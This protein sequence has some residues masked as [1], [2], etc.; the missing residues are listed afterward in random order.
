MTL[1][2]ALCNLHFAIAVRLSYP[3]GNRLRRLREY[4]TL[5]ERKKVFSF[6]PTLIF[7][8]QAAKRCQSRKPKGCGGSN[9]PFEEWGEIFCD[10]IIASLPVGRQERYLTGFCI[11]VILL[12]LMALAIE[13]RRKWE[14]RVI[15]KGGQFSMGINTRG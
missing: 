6:S 4:K 12:P 13:Q 9:K 15:T 8:E 11:I 5:V 1:Q 7:Q 3:S 10:D 2:F 14:L